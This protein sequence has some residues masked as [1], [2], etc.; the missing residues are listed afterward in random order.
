MTRT[1]S[2]PHPRLGAT[3]FGLA[4]AWAAP[5]QG[6]FTP[7]E[8]GSTF[9][10]ELSSL[11]PSPSTRG[12]FKVYQFPARRGDRL[13]A[14]MRS[15][16][17]DSYLRLGRDVGGITDEL[18][19]DDDTGG[20]TDARLRFTVPEDG[21]YLLI[22]QSLEEDGSGSFTIALEPTPAPTTA[23]PRPIRVGQTMSAELAETDAIQEDDDT[24]YDT[25]TVD[26]PAGQRLVVVMESG[27]VDAF[28]TL[29]RTDPAGEFE[30][31]SS[32]DDGDQPGDSTNARMRVRI[33]ESGTYEIRAN[34]IGPWTGPYRLTVLEGPEPAAT[35]SRQPIAAG[36]EVTGRLDE[37]DAALDDDSYYEYWIYPASAGDR[38]KIRMTSE[39]FDT[40][41]TF[42]RLANGSF[43]ELSSNDDGPDGTNSELD[44]SVPRAGEFAVRASSLGAG[45]FG[46]YT[47]TVTHSR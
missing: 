23:D 43:E 18:D 44:V 33:P 39:D 28:V 9:E 22:A 35:A 42:G 25:W 8:P 5:A 7:I 11:D 41:V 2:G 4:L 31:L 46:E 47:L 14:T 17:L 20:D 32:N 12:P 30:S 10:G 40:M 45:L 27:A 13:T 29:G 34:S 37:T 21:V 15:P 26:A 16:D 19:A 36:E 38:L 3:I 24:Y 1:A 6:Q